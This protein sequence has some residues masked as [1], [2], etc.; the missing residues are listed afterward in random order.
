M[1]GCI[2]AWREQC[3]IEVW[4][5]QGCILNEDVRKTCFYPTLQV[6]L[7]FWLFCAW[8]ESMFAN[9]EKNLECI[10][11]SHFIDAV[12]GLNDYKNLDNAIFGFSFYSAV[13]KITSL[14]SCFPWHFSSGRSSL[15]F[16]VATRGLFFWTVNYLSCHLEWQ[17]SGLHLPW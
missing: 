10:P 4:G 9:K 6:S 13:S 14:E 5:C 16:F 8:Q 11:Q 2:D 12:S 7:P 3:N 1:P 17:C 15:G